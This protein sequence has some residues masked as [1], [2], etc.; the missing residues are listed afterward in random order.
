MSEFVGEWRQEGNENKL[1]TCHQISNTS[2]GCMVPDNGVLKFAEFDIDGASIWKDTDPDIQGRFVEKNQ[3]IS[4]A[5]HD[6]N[7][8]QISGIIS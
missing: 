8:L 7:G 2:V 1:I 4:S 3:I 5:K 6:S